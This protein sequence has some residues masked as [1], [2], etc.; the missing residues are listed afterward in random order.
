ME[1]LWGDKGEGVDLLALA[2]HHLLPLLHLP[3]SPQPPHYL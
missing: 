2:L 1:V 3:F